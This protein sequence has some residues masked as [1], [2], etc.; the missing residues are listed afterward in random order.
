MRFE[1]HLRCICSSSWNRF[2]PRMLSSSSAYAAHEGGLVLWYIAL[3]TL[4]GSIPGI[5]IPKRVKQ[6]DILRDGLYLYNIYICI[7]W[8]YLRFGKAAD[9]SRG[10]SPFSF[11]PLALQD[12][13][14]IALL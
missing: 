1:A 14:A 4:Q 10:V 3:E 9:Q 7:R 13:I 11:R 6:E 2:F 12:W 8:R 5:G